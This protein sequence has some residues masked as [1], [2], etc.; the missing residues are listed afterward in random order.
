[1]LKG[2]SEHPFRA[3][4]VVRAAIAEFAEF[5][6]ICIFLAAVSWSGSRT[7]AGSGADTD[8]CERGE[9]FSVEDC[10]QFRP[11]QIRIRRR[12]HAPLSSLFESLDRKK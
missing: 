4:A 10:P 7:L 1:L 9:A 2:A 11:L 12:S 8:R 3:I 6:R 5:D